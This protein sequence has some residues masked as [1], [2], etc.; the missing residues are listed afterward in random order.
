[1]TRLQALGSLLAALPLL[2]CPTRVCPTTPHADTV[3]LLDYHRGSASRVHSI[4]AEAS[5]DQRGGQ[6]RV[7]GT[8]F[9]FVERP[10]N[11]RFDVMTQLGPAAILT[12]NE[13]QFAFLDQREGK[14]LYGEPCPANIARLMG[15]YLAADDVAKFLLGSTPVIEGASE[16]LECEDGLYKIVLRTA[17][18]A[19]QELDF[20]IGEG[21]K[22]APPEEQHLRL[23]RSEFFAP[24]GTTLLRVQFD[25]YQVVADVSDQSTPQRGVALPHYV[26]IEDPEHELDTEVRFREL[27]LND[28]V[29][30]DAF[31]QDAPPGAVVEESLCD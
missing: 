16:A 17:E 14:F 20:A 24:N 6:G 8:V 30:S 19:R 26:H 7:K 18:G 25:A 12:S 1:M 10:S 22:N 3:S 28:E 9:M 4:R 2:G 31:S 15:L 13:E 23:M 29:P 21:E 27:V 5:V 11:V